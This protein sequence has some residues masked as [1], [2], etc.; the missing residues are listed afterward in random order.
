[1]SYFLLCRGLLIQFKHQCLPA[2][3]LIDCIG[4]FR[5]G[6]SLGLRLNEFTP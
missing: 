4:A 3:V 6:V 5:E 1:M 2:Q